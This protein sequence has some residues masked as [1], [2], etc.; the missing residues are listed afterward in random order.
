MNPHPLAGPSP[1]GYLFQDAGHAVKQHSEEV[2]LKERPLGLV[3][4]QGCECQGPAPGGDPGAA[5]LELEQEG[6]L[7]GGPWPGGPSTQRGPHGRWAQRSWLELGAS[8]AELAEAVGRVIKPTA[9]RGE[10]WVLAEA[11]TLTSP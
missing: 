11:S 6:E 2:T 7:G 4:V 9:L 5:L 1:S 10:K 3:G 8:W